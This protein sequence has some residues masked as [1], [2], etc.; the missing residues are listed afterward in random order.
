[1]FSNSVEGRTEY[2]LLCLTPV[3]F[4]FHGGI[5]T[6]VVKTMTSPP[7]PLFLPIHNI[8]PPHNLLHNLLHNL[9]IVPPSPP[10]RHPAVLFSFGNTWCTASQEQPLVGSFSDAWTGLD[11]GVGVREEPSL[12]PPAVEL[13]SAQEEAWTESNNNKTSDLAP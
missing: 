2:T 10:P 7:P 13:S 4:F 11:S 12:K 8:R 5:R 6:A 9:T 1:M 3:F